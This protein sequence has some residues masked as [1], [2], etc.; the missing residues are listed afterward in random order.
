MVREEGE[1]EAKRLVYSIFNRLYFNGSKTAAECVSIYFA[2][3]EAKS[4]C[5]NKLVVFG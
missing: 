2:S 4:L 5:E 3:D 1:R